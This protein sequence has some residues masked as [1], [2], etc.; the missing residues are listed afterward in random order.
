MPRRRAPRPLALAVDALAQRLAPQSTLARVQGVWTSAVGA[1]LAAEASP[2]AERDGVL[3]VRC[4]SSVWA[5]EL[6]L[7]APALV[8]RV[9]EA[10]GEGL[11]LAL[12]CR[13]GGP[14]AP[15]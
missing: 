8:E 4:S 6:D 12:R 3:T 13:A 2:V 10:L 14:R 9:N 7:M 1:A 15:S 5:H 11:V